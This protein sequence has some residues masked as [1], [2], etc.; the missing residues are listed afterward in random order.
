MNKEEVKEAMARLIEA[1]KSAKD[2]APT[3]KLTG[4]LLI[5]AKIPKAKKETKS[6][7]ILADPGNQITSMSWKEP[8][9]VVVLAVGEGFYDETSGKEENLQVKPGNVIEVTP[10]SIDF[11]TSFGVIAGDTKRNRFGIGIC[12]DIDRRITFDNLD[13]YYKYMDVFLD[14]SLALKVDTTDNTD[15]F[16]GS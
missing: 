11:Y 3:M 12:R 4:D 8:N 10:N 1:F 6:G 13:D 14:S 5:V 7:L 16:G 2:L 9:F 15:L